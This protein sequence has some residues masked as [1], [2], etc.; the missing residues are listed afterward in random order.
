MSDKKKYL[1][2]EG[3]Q[4]FWDNVKL[5]IDNSI[6]GF[7]NFEITIVDELPEVGD[8]F[9]LY[10]V[11]KNEESL[12]DNTYEE[13]VWVRVGETEEYKWEEVGD[14]KMDL[15]GITEDI[16]TIK[17]NVEAL[18]GGVISNE[19]VIAKTFNEFNTKMDGYLGKYDA[20]VTATSSEDPTI[21]DDIVTYD[22]SELNKLTS[23]Y[24]IIKMIYKTG[25]GEA[26]V[27]GTV[28]VM[29]QNEGNIIIQFV[30]SRLEEKII[31]RGGTEGSSNWSEVASWKTSIGLFDI[32]GK[33]YED[34]GIYEVQYKM[35]GRGMQI[36]EFQLVKHI[37]YSA[38]TGITIDENGV[39]SS[40]FDDAELRDKIGGVESGLT[41]LTNEVIDNE[42]VIS[43]ALN[44]IDTTISGITE[45]IGNY[46]SKYDAVINGTVVGNTITYDYS[47]LNELTEGYHLVKIL[48]VVNDK[49]NMSME[50]IGTV[51]VFVEGNGE[52]SIYFQEIY[53]PFE[54]DIV[55]RVYMLG[56]WAETVNIP[57][58]LGVENAILSQTKSYDGKYEYQYTFTPGQKTKLDLVKHIDYSAGTGITIDENGVISSENTINIT[59]EI[60]SGSTDEQ[61]PSAKAV[62]DGVSET[63]QVLTKAIIGVGNRVP[64]APNIDG[65][66]TLKVTVTGGVPTYSWVL[67]A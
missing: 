24:H 6:S 47:S 50:I 1:D 51:R 39:I 9:K 7:T 42:Y 60:T 21:A 63:E 58:T 19:Y 11:P 20:V 30:Y 54:G 16:Q 38:G 3:L 62:W 22:F 53:N 33:G 57:L 4:L 64:E 44:E 35:S 65:T 55:Y 32:I 25:E 49:T 66:Y 41:N 29:S 13:Y 52:S 18:S 26:V 15:S 27:Y 59:T 36:P 61:V 2:L 17:D 31:I 67:D 23:G 8:S 43:K 28:N 40:V 14:T 10:L 12:S 46:I 48:I 5:Y 56:K 45:N 37:D 34:G